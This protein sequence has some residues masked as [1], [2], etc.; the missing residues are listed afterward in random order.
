MKARTFSLLSL[1]TLVA[2]AFD[3]TDA[4]QR[5]EG[6]GKGTII[7]TP[8]PFLGTPFLDGFFVRFGPPLGQSSSTDHHLMTLEVRA[9]RPDADSIRVTYRDK[10]ADDAYA[11]IVSFH[12]RV[13]TGLE[14]GETGSFGVYQSNL[15]ISRPSP[16]HVFVLRGFKLS[17][18]SGDEHVQRLAVFEADGVLTVAFEYGQ[19]FLVVTANVFQFEVDYAYLPP[20]AVRSTG[21]LWGH[22]L[23]G[24]VDRKNIPVGESV[25]RGFD[26]R[27]TDGGHHIREIGVQTP[28]D[29]RVEVFFND[30]NSDDP[31]AWSVRWAILAPETP[32]RKD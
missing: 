18:R 12:S 19:R 14:L 31:F 16:D 4:Q 22:V 21:E 7:K 5:F 29:G 23:E 25:L 2:L 24:G 15:L 6:T 26:F 11:Y 28:D 1:I 10:N 20:A 8:G 27:F 30:K 9:Q 32:V 17:S 13:A 3:A